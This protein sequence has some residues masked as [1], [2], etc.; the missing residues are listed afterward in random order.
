M[1]YLTKHFFDPLVSSQN[2]NILYLHYT[3]IIRLPNY[4]NIDMLNFNQFI[5]R[6]YGVIKTAGRHESDPMKGSHFIL[7]YEL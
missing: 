4:I 6:K 5:R 3:S 1:I 7:E 2:R